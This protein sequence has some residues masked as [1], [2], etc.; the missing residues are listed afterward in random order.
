M[1]RG[2][3]RGFLEHCEGPT[4]GKDVMA[5]NAKGTLKRVWMAAAALMVV[6]GAHADAVRAAP[7]NWEQTFKNDF[8]LNEIHL[9][10]TEGEVTFV[11]WKQPKEWTTPARTETYL[12]GV[13]PLIEAEKGT[14]RVTF[15]DKTPFTIEWA[16]VLNGK[17]QG[18]GTLLWDRKWTALD[19]FTQI[20]PSAAVSIPTTMLLLA[21]GLVGLVGFRQVQ[22]KRHS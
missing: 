13:G 16:E 5:M 1:T 4:S 15:A 3:Q 8:T 20:I 22:A 21:S 6:M 10:I 12:M 19:E 2:L 14:W 17:I 18:S 7:M 11:D 9:W